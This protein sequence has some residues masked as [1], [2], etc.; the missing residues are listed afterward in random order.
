MSCFPLPLPAYIYCLR[1]DLDS[2]HS[3]ILFLLLFLGTF[4]ILICKDVCCLRPLS[5]SHCPYNK[6]YAC[7]KS[8][9]PA[10]FCNL[11]FL[12]FSPCQEEDVFSC[13]SLPGWRM[14]VCD[15]VVPL[16][17]NLSFTCEPHLPANSSLPFS[18][19]FLR[20]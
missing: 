10:C 1:S 7:K 16:A 13:L 2:L 9:I 18:L 8:L 14:S 15:H 11:I 6:D 3:F 5:G 17:Y 19:F 12:N 20:F 4:H